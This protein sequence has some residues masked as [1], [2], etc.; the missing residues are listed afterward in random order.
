MSPASLLLLFELD[1]AR[2]HHLE[3]QFIRASGL[4]GREFDA[5][6]A[7]IAVTYGK[8]ICI[9]PLQCKMFAPLT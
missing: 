2:A 7:E 9:S 1:L 6:F 3:R 4:N 5:I 8:F